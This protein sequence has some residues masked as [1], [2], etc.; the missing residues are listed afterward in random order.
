MISLLSEGTAVGERVVAVLVDH[1]NNIA[2]QIPHSE[3]NRVH[4]YEFAC[5]FT[6][7]YCLGLLGFTERFFINLTLP[8]ALRRTGTIRILSCAP[9]M[10]LPMV[11]VL[12]QVKCRSSHH[13][14][15]LTKKSAL[16]RDWVAQF[17]GA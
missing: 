17:S 10:I 11:D 12:G 7:R 16:C 8:L 4:P 3:F 15:S 5:F 6:G 9:A 13:A 2:A 14:F 1:G